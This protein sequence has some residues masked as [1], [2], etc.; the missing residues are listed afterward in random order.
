MNIRSALIGGA[1]LV[2]ASAAS[3]APA[4]PAAQPHQHPSGQPA[5]G[6]TDHDCCCGKEMHEMM[7][8]MHEMMRMH[9]G[10]KMPDGIKMHSPG[11]MTDPPPEPQKN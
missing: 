2:A 7:T 9:Q 5:E 4:T 11:S 10:M 3:G 6:S 1:I 8:M